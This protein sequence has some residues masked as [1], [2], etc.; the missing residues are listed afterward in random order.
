MRLSRKND[1]RRSCRHAR[2]NMNECHEV[3]RLP[4]KTTLEPAWKTCKKDRFCSIAHRHGGATRKP[5][6]RDETCWSLKTSVSCE[7]FSIFHTLLLQIPRFP[8]S[9][10]MNPTNLPH[11]KRCFVRGLR[12]FSVTK[13]LPR[14][15]HLCHHLMQ[16]WH[17]D[18]QKTRNTTRLKL[19]ACHAKWSWRSPQCCA[20]HEKRNAS[21][22]NDATRTTFDTLW[23]MMKHVGLSQIVPRLPRETRGSPEAYGPHADGRERLRTVADA[24]AMSSEHILNP[25][26]PEWNGNP[27]YAFGKKS[28]LLDFGPC[29][30]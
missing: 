20:C 8:T 24:S 10:L 28:P 7:T 25:R 11:Q 13:R 12:Q 26:P 3:A 29:I 16:P 18:L 15:L 14:N 6:N 27:C 23:N 17:C 9:F 21:S 19:C 1:G 5:E 30:P 2:M 4:G 22:E